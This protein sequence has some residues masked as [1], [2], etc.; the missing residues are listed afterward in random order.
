MVF[1]QVFR[2]IGRPALQEICQ[3]FVVVRRV[4]LRHDHVYFFIN[5][6][7][8]G[9]P[10]Q[11]GEQQIDSFDMPHFPLIATDHRQWYRLIDLFQIVDV[12]FVSFDL[13][14]SQFF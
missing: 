14:Y 10:K 1:V 7:I 11:C 3:E 6:I 5:D 12:T 8:F 4:E 2:I 9:V 13:P